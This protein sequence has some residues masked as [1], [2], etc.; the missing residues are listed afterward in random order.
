MKT[1]LYIP[2]ILGLLL[3]LD[4]ARMLLGA[5]GWVE[6]MFAVFLLH[7]TWGGLVERWARIR[8]LPRLARQRAHLEAAPTGLPN[9]RATAESPATVPDTTASPSITT[10]AT[11]LSR[12]D[13]PAR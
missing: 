4:L 12:G 2:Y 9:E 8:Y 11:E 6:L 3:L 1:H 10:S 13:E 5:L 7:M